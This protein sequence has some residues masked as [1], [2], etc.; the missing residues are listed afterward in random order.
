MKNDES[1]Y[2]RKRSRKSIKSS[3]TTLLDVIYAESVLCIIMLLAICVINIFN[4]NLAQSIF[5]VVEKWCSIN[6]LE[7]LIDIFKNALF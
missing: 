2:R 1:Y 5:V 6:S 4:K 7:S 3:Q